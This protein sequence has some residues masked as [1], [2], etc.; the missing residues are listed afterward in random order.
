[1][2]LYLSLSTPA[3]GITYEIRYSIGT[4]ILASGTATAQEYFNVEWQNSFFGA[5]NGGSGIIQINQATG[6][7]SIPL[8][9][10]NAFAPCTWRIRIYPQSVITTLKSLSIQPGSPP[11]PFLIVLGQSYF[12]NPHATPSKFNGNWR[13]MSVFGGTAPDT[14]FYGGITGSLLGPIS[15]VNKIARFDC[16]GTVAHN[17]FATEGVNGRGVVIRAGNFTSASTVQINKIESINANSF[18]HATITADTIT[19]N[20]SSGDSQGQGSIAARKINGPVSFAGTLNRVV[21]SGTDAEILGAISAY[22]IGTVGSDLS[23][24][25][26]KVLKNNIVVTTDMRS[27]IEIRQQWEGNARRISVGRS[28]SERT[29]PTDALPIG[30]RMI[31]LHD[32]DIMDG[33]TTN[34]LTNQIIINANN[35]TPTQDLNGDGL[36]NTADFWRGDV[37]IDFP[38]QSNLGSDRFAPALD[39]TLIGPDQPAPFQAPYYKAL[40]HT[41]GGGAV[42]LAPFNFHQFTGPLGSGDVR[43]CN[44]FHTEFRAVDICDEP[45]RVDEVVI[46]HYGPVHTNGTGPYY[47][48]EF[49]PAF[50][51]PNGPTWFDVSNQFQV[52]TTRTSSSPNGNNRKVYIIPKD[53]NNG[54]NA[55]GIFRFRP[56]VAAGEGNKVRCSNVNGSPNVAYQSSVVSGDLGST[57]GTQHHWY[58]FRVGLLYPDCESSS[59]L[60][61]NDRVNTSDLAAWIHNP[62]EVNMDGR[63][64]AQDFALMSSAYEPE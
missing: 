27:P 52:D 43:H 35:N 5:C 34:P 2:R 32:T 56:L 19:T 48:I 40:S 8:N 46:D 20:I 4:L 51:D 54:F 17:I 49:R 47:R 25:D 15:G 60:F 3:E 13:G 28:L 61:E 63:I 23:A 36:I 6:S 44:P 21:S 29:D 37:S 1:M 58:Q 42:G 50:L 7:N 55:A 53:Q 33:E 26:A 57:T 64:C 30:N 18:L 62:F 16:D 38:G 10:S 22:A 11:E 24:V 41:F 14:V 45:T 9:T 31:I 12:A 59:M 39:E